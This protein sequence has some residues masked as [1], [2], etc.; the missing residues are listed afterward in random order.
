M[1]V[2]KHHVC[3]KCTLVRILPCYFNFSHAICAMA[4]IISIPV[5]I[6]L[7]CTRFKSNVLVCKLL[8]KTSNNSKLYFFPFTWQLKQ[9]NWNLTGVTRFLSQVAPCASRLSSL[10]SSPVM[11]DMFEFWFSNQFPDSCNKSWYIKFKL[12]I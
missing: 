7:T 12:H 8:H 6:R 1:N 3:H 9:C 4:L 5:V 2:G 10:K 11:A